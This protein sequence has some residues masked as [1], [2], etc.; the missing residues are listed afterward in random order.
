[1]GPLAQRA[2]GFGRAGWRARQNFRAP[3]SA[4][5]A[6]S[7]SHWVGMYKHIVAALDGSARTE[8]VLRQAERLARDHGAKLHLCRAI[9]VPV[10]IPI[11]AWALSGGELT[12]RLVTD[13]ERELTAQL[14]SLSPPLAGQVHV[15]VGRPAPVICDLAAQIP[16]DLIVLGSHGF[17]TLDRLL[18]TTAAKVVNHAPCS[19]LVV[20]PPREG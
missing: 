7:G 2:G 6:S 8:L 5:A 19:V 12:E 16:A 13:A 10:G 3:R 14:Q 18:G 20:R 4:L 15:R 1:M 9:N 11:E 17:D